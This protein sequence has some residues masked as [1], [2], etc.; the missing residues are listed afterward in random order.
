MSFYRILVGR[1]IRG[2]RVLARYT[3]RQELD[4]P[5][6]LVGEEDRRWYSPV[7][8]IVAFWEDLPF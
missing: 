4:S 3:L 1:T 8:R 5:Y 2:S 7:H 6:P